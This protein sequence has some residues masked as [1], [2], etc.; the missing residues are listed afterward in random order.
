M[1]IHALIYSGYGT[2]QIVYQ[3][4]GRLRPAQP[5]ETH[6]VIKDAFPE[7]RQTPHMPAL[8]ERGRPAW[9]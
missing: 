4:V 3:P 5:T 7:Y 9:S 8:C 2:Y 1:N 6:A